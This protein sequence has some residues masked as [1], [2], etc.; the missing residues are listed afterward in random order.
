LEVTP[1]TADIEY[2]MQVFNI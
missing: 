1:Y 2:L